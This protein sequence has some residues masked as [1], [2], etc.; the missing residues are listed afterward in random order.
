MLDCFRVLYTINNTFGYG[1]PCTMNIKFFSNLFLSLFLISCGGGGTNDTDVPST[2]KVNSIPFA[3]AGVDQTVKESITVTLDASDSKDDDGSI[4]SYQW[5]QVSGTTIEMD[6]SNEKV[7]RFETPVGIQD[8]SL[9]FS[10]T[11][12][13]NDGATKSDD[14]SIHVNHEN[15]TPR[16]DII[17]A[18]LGELVGDVLTVNEGNFIALNAIASDLDGEVMSYNWVQQSGQTL[19]LTGQD[20]PELSFNTPE[21]SKT[22]TLSFQLEITDNDDANTISEVDVVVTPSIVGKV[23]DDPLKNAEIQLVDLISGEVISSVISDANGGYQLA[24]PET[25]TGFLIKS[26]G[27]ML[28]GQPFTGEM[29]ALCLNV[30]RK[31]CH[32]TPLTTLI[33]HF[34]D[35]I[36]SDITNKAEVI[37]SLNQ[38]LNIDIE[39]DPFISGNIDGSVDVDEIRMALD[40]GSGLSDWIDEI[41]SY[42]E[43]NEDTTPEDFFDG[44][45]DALRAH[46]GED[47]SVIEQSEVNLQ[48]QASGMEGLSLSYQ[49]VQL[50]GP[51]VILLGENTSSINFDAP[52]VTSQTALQFRLSVT[53]SEGISAFDSVIVN[54]A[55]TNEAPIT[56]AGINQSVYEQES[57]ILAGQG[58]DS[59][60][61]ITSALWMQDAGTGVTL[62]DA[63]KLAASFTA[64]SLVQTETL[65]FTLTLTDNEGT[66]DSDSVDVIVA[67]SGSNQAPTV[68]AGDDQMVDE[69]NLVQLVGSASDS[70]GN[71]SNYLWTQQSGVNVS[72]ERDDTASTTFTAPTLTESQLLEFQLVATDN[73]GESN[74]DEIIVTI[75]P[76]NNLPVVQAGNNQSVFGNTTVFLNGQATDT[77]G[78]VD[79]YTWSQI[80]GPRVISIEDAEMV[81]ANFVAPEVSE[82]ESYSFSLTG[83]DNEG[84]SNSDSVDITINPQTNAAPIADAGI[85]QSVEEESNVSLSGTGTDSDGTIVSYH[86][87]QIVGSQNIVITNTNEATA[88]FV[89][90][91]LSNSETYTFRLT[92]LDDKGAGGVDSVDIVIS[93][94]TNV[95]PIA[96]GGGNQTV[97]EGDT[98]TLDGSGSSDSDGTITAYLWE[99]VADLDSG[100]VVI[101]DADKAVANFIAPS[102]DGRESAIVKLTVWDD[103]GGTD[104]TN[105]IY[106]YVE[107]ESNSPPIADGGGNQ[108]VVGG[109]TVYL[110]GTG[111]SDTDGT[112]SSYNWG[113]M[114]GNGI[115]I[116]DASNAIANFVAPYSNVEQT[117]QVRLWVFDDFGDSDAI[118]VNITINPTEAPPPP[119]EEPN[120]P[121]VADAGSDKSVNELT[122][123]NLYGSGS[124]DSDGTIT[125][126]LWGQLA[127]P[128]VEISN[129]NYINTSFVAPDVTQSV[130]IS[131]RLLVWDNDGDSDDDTVT[132]T[133]N[134][135]P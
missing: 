131:F 123:V 72:L 36:G 10:L 22:E 39:N 107:D 54:V 21:V 89:A 4:V 51:S 65:T 15:L 58:A 98:V 30:E 93:P 127:G 120:V 108:T 116:N 124:S 28:N 46:A 110:D 84:G 53:T 14:V 99:V 102:V 7:V 118:I 125:S 94:K 68:N 32:I 122:T 61:S 45:N 17:T 43:G 27:G 55:P 25:E 90:P 101:S 103:D 75:N 69:Q 95:P 56:N 38:L 16:I 117:V 87:D 119:P 88:S 35:A 8:Y 97:I 133:I 96:N 48:G 40:G 92:V 83:W 12:E 1:L 121:P 24:F 106:I 26:S 9:I 80:S 135:V 3:N 18:S 86:W 41:V 85:D 91:T 42:L 71:I 31:E 104:T 34:S 6:Y 13:D 50:T 114:S 79:V 81:T 112:I 82:S 74:S 76:V 70:D 62:I 23:V 77:D 20:T 64:P 37:L 47:Q 44:V 59:D 29:Y 111:S 105:F 11:V 109:V 129:N 128:T 49:W 67:P 134:P 66:S 2:T 52:T 33:K 100:G 57:V 78:T 115:T 126:Y 113:V 5:S 60:G 132:I 73:D 130:D 63:D 19:E